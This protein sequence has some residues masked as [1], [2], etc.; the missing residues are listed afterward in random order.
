VRREGVYRE[1]S[2]EEFVAI[3]PEVDKERQAPLLQEKGEQKGA[4]LESGMPAR[5]LL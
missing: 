4:E 3:N 5:R 2:T 1:V